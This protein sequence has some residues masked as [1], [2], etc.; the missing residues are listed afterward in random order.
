MDTIILSDRKDP[1]LWYFF[2]VGKRNKSGCKTLQHRGMDRR[3]IPEVIFE[4]A[5]K[6]VGRAFPRKLAGWPSPATG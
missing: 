2:V 6:P 1:I 4:T 5:F 3:P